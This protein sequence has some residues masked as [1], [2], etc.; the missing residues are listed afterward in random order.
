MA[1]K[2]VLFLLLSVFA[3]ALSA[4]VPRVAEVSG[5]VSKVNAPE[6]VLPRQNPAAAKAAE[7]LQKFLS[8]AT[9]QQIPILK[10]PSS[11]GFA[12]ILGGNELLEKAGLDLKKLPEEGYYI[13]RQGNKLFLAGQDSAL[14]QIKR[15]YIYHKRGTLSAAY[16]FLQR[17]A[18][19]RFYFPGKYGT[20]VPRR[21][22]LYL[23]EKIR[24]I[25]RPDR[26]MRTTYFGTSCR[27]HDDKVSFKAGLNLQQLRLR[28][29]ENAYPFCHGLNRLELVQR[30][31]KT[32][33][34]FFALQTDGKRYITGNRPGFKGQLCFSSGV[35]EQ[36]FQ[37]AKKYF[38][39]A[40]PQEVNGKHYWSESLAFGRSFCVMPQDWMYWCNC[41]KCRKIAP[42]GRDAAYSD[43]KY[44]QAIS[45]FMWQFTS[46][47]AER[48]A[49]EGFDCVINQMAYSPYDKIPNVK[50]APN[51]QVQVAVNGLGGDTFQDKRDMEKMSSWAKKMG[52]PVMLW[53][54]AQGKHMRKNIPG[55]PPMMP[56]HLGN[57]LDRCAPYFDGGF[58]EAETDH[59]IFSYLNF[60]LTSQK[61]W[62]SSLD[63][64]KIL[65]EHYALMFGK[66]AAM[67]RKVYET[68]EDNWT[69]K[70]LGNVEMT[71]I[72]PVTHVPESRTIWTAIYSPTQMKELHR[73]CD[74]AKKAAASDK[75]AVERIEFI[76]KHL[77][78]PIDDALRTWLNA[79]SALDFWELPFNKKG[80]LRTLSGQAN[81]VATSFEVRKKGNEV[82][83]LFE[84]QE[85]AMDDIKV[86][87]R[88]NDDKNIWA[89]S[90]VELFLNPSGD[91]K[92]YYQIIVNAAG[93]AAVNKYAP[94]AKSVTIP[95][96][97]VKTAVERKKEAWHVAI[98]LPLKFT[99]LDRQKAIPV[100]FGRHRALEK[101][102]VKYAYYH[103][104]PIRKPEKGF[105]DL[106]IWGKL[107]TENSTSNP[108]VN[109]EFDEKGKLWHLWSRGGVKGGS[110][111]HFDD[112]LFIAGGRSL[113]LRS[114]S[115]K[116]IN[117]VQF[118]PGLK[119]GKTYRLSYFLRIQ[120][121]K[122]TGAGAYISLGKNYGVALPRR[123]ITG[124]RDWSRE[125]HI[126]KTPEQFP[127]DFTPSV[128]LWLWDGT[129]E[130]WFDCVR[131]EEVK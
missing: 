83:F 29:S 17:F 21:D 85:P 112:T 69:K 99:G 30:F 127:P 119:P 6:I 76:R 33:P 14:N 35:R 49:K 114:L 40:K 36:I 70:I 97:M 39:G 123:R 80:Y 63:T 50:L 42:G 62:D 125:I 100:N 25:E 38:Q 19:V 3:L 15:L 46:E 53:T 120:D 113:L 51:V 41:E 43:P 118:L 130:A 57:F 24:I 121:V 32:H 105:H 27:W 106:A 54:Y 91:R 66:G 77:L 37:D 111:H 81:E 26:A 71:S 48:L 7:E 60:Y 56:R 28:Y 86:K 116:S 131:V 88:K 45:D 9:G 129:G 13:V 4:K 1:K 74:D 55:I 96:T 52:H 109:G 18:G 82:M 22:G 102:S 8:E 107:T 20:I 10:A 59:F 104:N 47:I 117:A 95:A 5:T 92:N 115:G 90:A 16:D 12:L 128:G 34:E 44:R 23:P 61:L 79:Q 72:G 67:M 98:T 11:K 58:F 73:L 122:G 2:L 126:F 103:W 93:F 75:G 101:G 87:V 78:G 84:C 110:S 89:D 94:G 68:L 31:G 65:T 108:V 64:E 124:T